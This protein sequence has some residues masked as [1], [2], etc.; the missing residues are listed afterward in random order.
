MFCC[1]LQLCSG[2]IRFVWLVSIWFPYIA[3]VRLEKIFLYI[4]P[5]NRIKALSSFS[6]LIYLFLLAVEGTSNG[7]CVCGR[8][9]SPLLCSCGSSICPKASNPALSSSI[10]LPSSELWGL[11]LCF[12]PGVPPFFES[13]DL[14]HFCFLYPQVFLLSPWSQVTAA[15][16]IFHLCHSVFCSS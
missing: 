3:K 5:G 9:G 7:I 12:Y 1:R 13:Q 16:R 11:C 14:S 10:A 6:I 15:E 8:E 2:T 4:F